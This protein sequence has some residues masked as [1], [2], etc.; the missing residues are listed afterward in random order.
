MNNLQTTYRTLVDSFQ[1]LV[2]ENSAVLTEPKYHIR[3]FFP[4]PEYKYRDE[5]Q[6]V[7]EDIIGFDIAYRYIREDST[8]VQLNTF[9]YTGTDGAE[10]TGTFTDWVVTQG[11]MKHKT[12]DEDMGRYVWQTENIADG[13][14]TN[15]N[16]L[17]IPINKGEKVEIKVRSISEAGYPENPLRSEWSNTII[18]EFPPTLATTN[19]IAD[20]IT[21]VNDDALTLTIQNNL[22]SI[23]VSEHLNDTIPNSNSVNGLYYK[24]TA[25]N[26]AYEETGLSDAGT[27]VVNSISVQDKIEKI[28]AVA[29][30]AKKVAESNAQNI[31]DISV[32]MKKKHDSY[33]VS[34]GQLEDAVDDAVN[35]ARDVSVDMHTFVTINRDDQGAGHPVLQAREYVLV[36]DANI[37]KAALILDGKNVKVTNNLDNPKDSANLATVLVQDVQ[38]KS[39]DGSTLNEKLDYVYYTLT[40]K[41][42][43]SKVLEI[44]TS[45]RNIRQDV[46]SNTQRITQNSSLINHINA[47]IIP[48][49]WD[50]NKKR[51]SATTVCVGPVGQTTYL[52]GGTEGQLQIGTS[53]SGTGLGSLV[54]SDFIAR[55]NGASADGISLNDVGSR[56][57]QA[58]DNINDLSTMT[59]KHDTILENIAVESQ[60][61]GYSVNG[62]DGQFTNAVITGKIRASQFE[63]GSGKQFIP[64]NTSQ[65]L[66]NAQFASLTLNTDP[67]GGGE[68]VNV[69]TKIQE[70]QSF[71]DNHKSKLE[72]MEDAMNFSSQGGAVEVTNLTATTELMTQQLSLLSTAGGQNV[73]YSIKATNEGVL[74]IVHHNGPQGNVADSVIQAGDVVLIDGS[75]GEQYRVSEYMHRMGGLDLQAGEF[76]F[77]KEDVQTVN[78]TEQELNAKTVRVW[79]DEVQSYIDVA[80]AVSP[81]TDWIRRLVSKMKWDEN[82]R[83]DMKDLVRTILAE[84]EEENNND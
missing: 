64:R 59:D 61:G 8:S 26:I 76:K 45:V 72:Q 83:N 14:Q 48:Q 18:M 79:I 13:T 51:L 84:L 80:N 29:D 55:L 39:P 2:R 34:I 60:S 69:L 75:T 37:Q 32:N 54:A 43:Q 25:E 78:M 9:S 12:Y 36:D 3:G 50:D 47:S 1:T 11:P 46:S 28:D 71:T 49:F 74:Q 4:I 66:L 31:K 7:T 33:E 35:A 58:E 42:E 23:G 63:V 20:L 41:A 10:Y 30:S 70:F 27:T 81:T 38:L 62:V 57:E 21:M 17:D 56:L 44:D 77:S 22:D 5:E 19:Q 73:V 53:E 65:E 40:Q 82:L 15:I 68:P 67:E 52:K 16:Q 24:H 6:T